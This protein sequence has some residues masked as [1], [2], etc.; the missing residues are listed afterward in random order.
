[1]QENKISGAENHKLKN[2]TLAED[3]E[4]CHHR[5]GH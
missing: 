4:T 2:K 5:I 3:T 1:M